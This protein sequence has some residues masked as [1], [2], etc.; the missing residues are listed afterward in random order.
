MADRRW[1]EGL[2]LGI[3]GTRDLAVVGTEPGHFERCPFCGVRDLGQ[4]LMHY[5]CQLAAGAPPAVNLTSK[6]EKRSGRG[7]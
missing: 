6:A 7:G 2:E 5:D 1:W 3:G 4:V